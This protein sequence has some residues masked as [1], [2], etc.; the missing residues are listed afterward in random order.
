V[1]DCVRRLKWSNNYRV[2]IPELDAQHKGVFEMVEA[3]GKAASAEAAADVIPAVAEKLVTLMTRHFALEERLMR[4]SA[5]P[6]QDWHRRQH[7]TARSRIAPLE[8]GLRS[9]DR[10]AAEAFHAF[11]TDWIDHH[12][13]ITDRLLAAY[14]QNFRWGRA[15]GRAS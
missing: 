8:A 12:I 13:R 2:F 10:Q 1:E 6:A 9:G 14:L 4:S 3:L 7:N 15:V 5:Y 11:A